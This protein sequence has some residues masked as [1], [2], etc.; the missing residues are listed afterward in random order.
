[1]ARSART[2]IEGQVRRVLAA[3]WLLALTLGC[4]RA[5]D[6][7][8]DSS[9]GQGPATDRPAAATPASSTAPATA[10]P[11]GRVYDETTTSITAKVGERFTVA[12]SGSTSRPFE[13]KLGSPPAAGVLAL[14][15]HGYAEKAPVGCQGCGGGE[16]AFT[17]AFEASGKGGATV[18]IVYARV[19]PA[20]S[21][22]TKEIT[23]QVRVE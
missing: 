2:G 14:V 18:R 3:S 10:T 20:D 1:M 11:Q 4:H 15:E 9:A 8:R 12:L 5:A 19:A 21:P 16:G 22:P 23:I 6:A 13:W 17:F 7:P